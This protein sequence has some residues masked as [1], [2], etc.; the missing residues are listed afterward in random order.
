MRRSSRIRHRTGI[1]VT[2]HETEQTSLVARSGM[3]AVR[4]YQKVLSPVFGGNC[5][6]YPTC[7]QYTYEAIEI[8]G[9]GKGSGLGFKRICRCHPWHEGGHDPVP[10]SEDAAIQTTEGGDA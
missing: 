8:H 9:L 3:L 5:R 4:G 1:I 6:Y 7:S 10:G 2:L